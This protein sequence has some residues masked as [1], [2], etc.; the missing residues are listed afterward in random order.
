VRKEGKVQEAGLLL[1]NVEALATGESFPDGE[2]A[3]FGDGSVDCPF[4]YLKV[5]VVYREE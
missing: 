4:T 5:E 1:Q 3:C 2:I